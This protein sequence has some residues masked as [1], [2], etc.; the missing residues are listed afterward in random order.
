MPTVH[1][2]VAAGVAALIFASAA[3]NVGTALANDLP[4]TDETISTTCGAG[5]IEK[6]SDT[7]IESCDFAFGFSV[8]R[9]KGVSFNIGWT[10]CK[11]VGTVPI[12]KNNKV[13]NSVLSG[14]CN[15]LQ[16]VLGMPA[17]SGC[18]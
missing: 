7:P 17:G 4:L 16:P 5:T 13:N 11:S 1:T 8:D 2:R 18:S 9:D 15:L 10:N 6:C 3:V 14:S 12:Y